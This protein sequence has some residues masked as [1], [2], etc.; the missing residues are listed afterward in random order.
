MDHSASKLNT[1]HQIW[2]NYTLN[3]ILGKG[4]RQNASNIQVIHK[5]TGEIFS[6]K[7]IELKPGSP[8]EDYYQNAYF[9]ARIHQTIRHKNILRCLEIEEL[10]FKDG[11]K[12]L[13]IFQEQ[14]TTS[15]LVKLLKMR[16][17]RKR[18]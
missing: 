6:L 4:Y 5:H 7:S 18:L 3:Q 9:S 13:L 12:H 17:M 8:D 14:G 15:L 1:K 11:G 10:T 16:E 2:K